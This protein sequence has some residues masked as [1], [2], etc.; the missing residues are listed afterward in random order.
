MNPEPATLCYEAEISLFRGGPE[1]R[2][3]MYWDA[4]NDS[5]AGALCGWYRDDHGGWRQE[6]EQDMILERRGSRTVR[7]STLTWA[8]GD[9]SSCLP[10][11]FSFI[12]GF[13]TFLVVLGKS[14]LLPESQLLHP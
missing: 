3:R 5:Q 7:E 2:V 12:P 4:Y 10:F 11:T 9:V 8:L 14:F 13:A 6:V 1:V